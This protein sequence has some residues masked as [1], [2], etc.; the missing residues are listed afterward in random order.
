MISPSDKFTKGCLLHHET[1]AFDALTAGTPFEVGAG[2]KVSFQATAANYTGSAAVTLEESVD[3]STYWTVVP[4]CT[5]TADGQVLG[6]AISTNWVRV[7]VSVVSSVAETTV[8]VVVTA[9]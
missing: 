4:D 5:I 6:K 2:S 1:L 9:K 3:G 7:K 8:A